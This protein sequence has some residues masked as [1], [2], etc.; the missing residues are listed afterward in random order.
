MPQY[1]LI[2]IFGILITLS[3]RATVSSDSTSGADFNVLS[4]TELSFSP[5]DTE[6]NIVIQTVNDELIET[7]ETFFV[8]LSTTSQVVQ[9][10]ERVTTITITDNDGKFT[11]QCKKSSTG[12]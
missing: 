11:V 8:N 12:V 5:G 3:Y 2:L 6:K 7:D 1:S 10:N 9:I 4:S